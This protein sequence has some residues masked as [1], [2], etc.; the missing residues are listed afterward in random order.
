M[1]K[2]FKDDFFLVGGTAIALYLGHRRSIDF[3]L[4]SLEVFDNMS[5]R[6]RLE[7]TKIINRVVVDKKGELT[8][9]IDDVKLTFFHY[10]FAVHCSADFDGVIKMPDLLSL[11]TMKAYVLGRRAKWKDYVDLYFIIKDEHSLGEIAAKG[12]QIFGG[13]FNEKIFRTQ[14]AYFD[15]IDYSE[16]IEFMPGFAVDDETVKKSLTDFSL[17]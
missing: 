9:F 2:E 10:P 11:A 6:A 13:E 12:K 4:A 16:Q 15:D 1:L 3:V 17:T 5:M 7:P 14:L 8:V